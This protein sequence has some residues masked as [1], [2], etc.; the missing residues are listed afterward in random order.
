MRGEGRCQY[1]PDCACRYMHMHM[2]MLHMHMHMH[3]HGECTVR[4]MHCACS[5]A[6]RRIAACRTSFDT[7]RT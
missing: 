6:G 1:V 5:I 2:H 3:M 7:L 4:C